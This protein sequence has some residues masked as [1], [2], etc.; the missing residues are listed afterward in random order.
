MANPRKFSEKIALHTQKQAEETAA[1]EQVMREV[2]GAKRV[3][4]QK[5]QL[6]INQSL[7]AYRG[8]SLPNVNQITSTSGGEQQ[9]VAM[10]LEDG[11][12]AYDLSERLDVDRTRQFCSQALRQIGNDKQMND[13]ILTSGGQAYLSPPIDS[14]WRR[15]TSDSALHQTATHLQDIAQLMAQKK[16][17][18]HEM[19]YAQL[20]SNVCDPKKQQEDNIL[21]HLSQ[22]LPKSSEIPDVD[23]YPLVDESSLMHIAMSSNTGS[24]PDLTNL[25]FPSPLATPIDIED[26]TGT[27][28]T[29]PY[30]SRSSPQTMSGNLSSTLSPTQQHTHAIETGLSEVGLTPL[31][32][33]VGHSGDRGGSRH[34]SPGPS[35]SPSS[36]HRHHHNQNILVIGGG[37]S[38]SRGHQHVSHTLK[39]QGLAKETKGLSLNNYSSQQSELGVY[40][41]QQA[42]SAS[43][44]NIYGNKPEALSQISMGLYHNSGPSDHSCSAPTSPVAHSISPVDS[45]GLG[46]SLPLNKSP[47][48]DTNYY[49][50]QHHQQAKSLQQQLEQIKMLN[51]A[52]EQTDQLS[53]F[54]DNNS[55]GIGNI[56]MSHT[57]SGSGYAAVDVRSSGKSETLVE[58][59]KFLYPD[60]LAQDMMSNQDTLEMAIQLY[61]MDSSGSDT[62][63]QSP[64]FLSTS[65]V[66]SSSHPPTPKTPQ[67]PTS[68]PD[69]VLTGP[70]VEEHLMKQDFAS[71]LSTAMANLSGCFDA[72]FFPADEALRAGLDPIDLD[73]LQILTDPDISVITDP[74]TEETFRLD[75]S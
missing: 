5:Q 42:Y 30:N 10:R 68:I 23:I 3:V 40:L 67:T 21:S 64:S 34:S 69:I 13:F 28:I 9:G 8:G 6:L 58:G 32:P 59:T 54:S 37:S 44:H 19:D 74:A 62:H 63:L 35:P 66:L 65:N 56:P 33:V 75:R 17:P 47:F 43:S 15:A 46:F 52:T 24:L 31:T 57:S 55:P 71:G 39:Q 7:G 27:L 70:G 61:G 50:Q 14:N 51:E 38:R 73:G 18:R 49:F 22:S 41:E 16:G 36:R 1:F 12:Q 48:T 4:H 25:Q 2:L 45:P 72:D 26:H 53:V 60:V 20:S 29:S 11:K